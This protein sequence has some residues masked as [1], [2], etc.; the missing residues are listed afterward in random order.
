MTRSGYPLRN[1]AIAKLCNCAT[2]SEL[3]EANWVQ[4]MAIPTLDLQLAKSDRGE[5][6]R[7]LIAALTEPG[8]LYLKNVKGYDPGIIIVTG[9]L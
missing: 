6:A 9:K 1:W 2:S 8:F 4:E 7:Q 5:A 3:P